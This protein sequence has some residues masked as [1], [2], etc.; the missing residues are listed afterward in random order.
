[1][2]ALLADIGS[3]LVAGAASVPM[4]L[5]I[6]VARSWVRSHLDSFRTAVCSSEEIAKAQELGES[7]TSVL[8]TAIADAIGPLVGGPPVATVSLLLLKFGIKNL[9]PPG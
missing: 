8:L 9:C 7:D 4:A 5:R 3:H 2:D 6:A 1:M